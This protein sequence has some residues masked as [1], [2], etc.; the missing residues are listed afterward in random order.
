M[1][2]FE[3]PK[4]NNPHLEDLDSYKREYLESINSPDNFFLN[5]AIENLDWFVKP[6]LGFNNNF[7][8]AAWFED[9]IL[10]ISYNCIDRHAKKKSRKKSN[11]LARR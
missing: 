1:K 8:N 3:K 10:N 11:N 7:K 9:G 4:F 5:K 6:T 2:S